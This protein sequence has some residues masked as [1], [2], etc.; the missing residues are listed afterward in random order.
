MVQELSLKSNPSDSPHSFDFTT[1]FKF[2]L[3]GFDVFVS[4]FQLS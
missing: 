2:M 3:S 4:E 1:S